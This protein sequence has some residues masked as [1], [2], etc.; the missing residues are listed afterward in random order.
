MWNMFCLYY[1]L[2]DLTIGQIA[3]AFKSFGLGYFQ[4]HDSL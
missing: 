1:G 4:Q 3:Y 2:I